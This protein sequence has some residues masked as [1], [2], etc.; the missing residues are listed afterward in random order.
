MEESATKIEAPY[1]RYKNWKN[2]YMGGIVW[3]EEILQGQVP[4]KAD[5]SYNLFNS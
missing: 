2:V 4:K 5:N 1:E 3:V